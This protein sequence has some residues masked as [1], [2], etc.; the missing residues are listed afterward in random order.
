M[1]VY[2]LVVVRCKSGRSCNVKK[3]ERSLRRKKKND[4]A[5][6]NTRNNFNLCTLSYV[7]SNAMY[8]WM[9]V[10]NWFW[11]FIE[12]SIVGLPV[13]ALMDLRNLIYVEFGYSDGGRGACCFLFKYFCLICQFGLLGISW[14]KSVAVVFVVTFKEGFIEFIGRDP[15]TRHGLS[16]PQFI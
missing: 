8:L 3:R 2:S 5:N 12:V 7:W 9:C 13:S 4:Y 11:S 16:K 1:F 6:A 14:G 15:V 10:I